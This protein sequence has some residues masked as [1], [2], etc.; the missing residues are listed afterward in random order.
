MKK[1]A[2]GKRQKA[3]GISR[4]IKHIGLILFSFFLLPSSFFLIFFW[5]FPGWN[6]K[7]PVNIVVTS[8]DE[9]WVL[10]VRPEEKKLVE[11]S[12][13]DNTIVK[14]GN[15]KWQARSLGRLS[16]LENNFDPLKSAGW[17]LLEVP[18]DSV[19]E[20]TDFGKENISYLSQFKL[21]NRFNF[22]SLLDT[23]K[24]IKYINSLNE[25]QILKINIGDTMAARII[26]DPAGTE[27]VEIDSEALSIQLSEWFRIE[28]LRNEGLTVAIINASGKTNAGSKLAR[29]LEHVG[30]RVISVSSGEG[31]TGLK[32]KQNLA[33]KSE[34]V[35]KLSSWLQM[36]PTV[37][38]F[39]A[40]ADILIVV[41]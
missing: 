38:D 36:K 35:R 17:E 34:T 3:E 28:S 1:K 37:G 30:L 26:A 41:K 40:R 7:D 11:I 29:Q 21:L 14:V 24:L 9:V 32:I 22:V 10:G 19:V 16:K 27:L 20:I 33:L 2:E 39:D 8:G 5:R 15:G 6:G 4:K 23:V 18:V 12:I 31:E 13:P 25:N